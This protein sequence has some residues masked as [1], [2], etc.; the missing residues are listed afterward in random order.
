MMTTL[1]QRCQIHTPCVVP[2]QMVRCQQDL[3]V[4]ADPQMALHQLRLGVPFAWFSSQQSHP[5]VKDSHK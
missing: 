2:P 5:A 4:Q 1:M 3:R